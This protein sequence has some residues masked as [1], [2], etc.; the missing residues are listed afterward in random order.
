MSTY[1][2]STGTPPPTDP[3]DATPSAPLAVS[4]PRRSV[5]LIVVSAVLAVTTAV[6]AVLLFN[7]S[8]ELDS[9]QSRVADL[10]RGTSDLNGQVD[11]LEKDKAAL[12]AR[13]NDL[14]N[15]M[16][17]LER[18]NERLQ[19]QVD[20]LAEQ[21]IDGVA[22]DAIDGVF[23]DAVKDQ[24]LTKYGSPDELREV[25]Q[26][27]CTAFDSGATFE[28]A[29]DAGVSAGWTQGDIGYLIGVGVGAYCPEHSDVTS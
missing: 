13:N 3:S 7:T 4:A 16:V 20:V 10:E 12:D 11:E 1:D 2:P 28:E 24:G 26:A 19:N 23:D 18:D 14:E 6:L 5:G 15:Q 27:T 9:A 25:V 22:G 29:V 21:A 8:Q 17:G